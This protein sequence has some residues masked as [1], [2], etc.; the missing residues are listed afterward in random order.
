MSPLPVTDEQAKAAAAYAELG[1]TGV[2][3]VRGG[4]GWVA[5]I[6]GSLPDDLVALAIGNQVRVAR[7]EQAHHLLHDAKERLRARGVLDPE[8]MSPSLAAPLLDAAASETDPSLAEL[9]ARLLANAL[10]PE[11]KARVRRKFIEV[12]KS[13]DPLDAR[14]FQAL[15]GHSGGMQPSVVQVVSS[16][17]ETDPDDVEVSLGNLS[18]LGLI[19]PPQYVS[20]ANSRQMAFRDR[21]PLT[22]FGRQFARAVD[23]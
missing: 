17:L 9:W 10:D 18:D 19:T 13:M 21:A 14:V 11:R 7:W 16:R 22:P 8:P 2:E 6:L 1:K 15:V 12:I 20:G 5:R 3:A 4:A 23:P